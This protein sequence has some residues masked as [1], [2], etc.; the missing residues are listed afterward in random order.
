M[1]K[2]I[3]IDH[4]EATPASVEEILLEI[5]ESFHFIFFSL[6]VE[7]DLDT[8]YHSDIHEV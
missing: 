3:E 5:F 4:N 7:N 8:L 6:S 2:A 1:K